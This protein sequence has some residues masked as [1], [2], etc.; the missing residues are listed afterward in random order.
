MSRAGELLTCGSSPQLWAFCPRYDPHMMNCHAACRDA[1]ASNS[2]E[3]LLLLL[4]LLASFSFAMFIVPW[5]QGAVALEA[6]LRSTPHTITAD[7]GFYRAQFVRLVASNWIFSYSVS[8]S[9]G[10]VISEPHTLVSVKNYTTHYKTNSSLG[11]RFISYTGG[12]KSTSRA[13][14]RNVGVHRCSIYSRPQIAKGQTAS[15]MEG[16]CEYKEWAGAD[17][18]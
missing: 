8:K 9:T 16:S 4:L 15:N 2:W 10:N 13:H 3:G 18:R 7:T 6:T 12:Q 11:Y 17:N 14:K 5:N 1:K